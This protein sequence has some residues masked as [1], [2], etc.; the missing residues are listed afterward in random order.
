MEKT[1]KITKFSHQPDMP[2]G[3]DAIQRDPDRL[4]QWA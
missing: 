1:Y 2:K 4:E 3:Q